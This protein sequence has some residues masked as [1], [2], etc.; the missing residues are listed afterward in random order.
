MK[1]DEEKDEILCKLFVPWLGIGLNASKKNNCWQAQARS[2]KQG[3]LTT[4]AV[5]IQERIKPI[6][7]P[8][9]LTA[10]PQKKPCNWDIANYARAIKTIEDALVTNGIIHNDTCKL[11]TQWTIKQPISKKPDGIFIVLEG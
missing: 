5:L 3:K 1:A 7:V 4:K 11:V 10:Y 6:T 9:R 2:V 8:V